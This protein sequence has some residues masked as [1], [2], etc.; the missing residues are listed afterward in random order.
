MDRPRLWM[1]CRDIAA[2]D[3]LGQGSVELDAHGHSLVDGVEQEA[4]GFLLQL[5]PFFRVHGGF[6]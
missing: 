2:G 1:V 3:P 4:P 6:R 5:F